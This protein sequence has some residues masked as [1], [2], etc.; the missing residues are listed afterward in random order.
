M[1]EIKNKWTGELIMTID[2]LSDANLSDADLSDANLSGADL[3]RANLSG[4][5]L[6]GADL[7][8][9]NLSGANLSDADL[10]DANLND[11][12]LSG[13][14]LSDAN[15]SDADLSDANL[16][17]ADL[18]RAN[19]S[20]ADLSGADLSDAN[21]SG[22]NLSD[23]N[24]RR[25]TMQNVK[26]NETTAFLLIQC[27]EEGD[28]ICFKKASNKIVKLLIPYDALRS[29]ATSLKCR[30]SK[31]LVIEIQELDGTKSDLLSIC[32]SRSKDFIYT[33]GETIT[34]ED[35]DTDRF[36]ECS[37][38]IHFFINRQMAVQYN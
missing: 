15:L 3:R 28:F 36:N 8:D 1:I 24:L 25:A 29:S 5:D 35:Y 9:A 22:A 38:G 19:L 27:P 18:R 17:G 26:I 12:N 21:L 4:A 20:G 30:A 37:T 2:S 23:A 6:S 31:A 14:N 10:S 33:V 32:S 7:S 34:V 13:A 11:A 16:S